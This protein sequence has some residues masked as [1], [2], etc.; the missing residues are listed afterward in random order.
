MRY[1]SFHEEEDTMSS[2]IHYLLI[3]DHA[4]GA[5]LEERPFIDGAEAVQAYGAAEEE[6]RNNVLI[7]IVLVASDSIE[8]IR[9]THA[10][11]FAGFSP[12]SPFLSDLAL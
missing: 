6:H 2:M 3:F 8:T 4:K 11:Y 12:L 9:L 5:L 7:E 10:N 1:L